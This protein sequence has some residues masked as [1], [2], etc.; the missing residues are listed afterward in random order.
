MIP[1]MNKLP[2]FNIGEKIQYNFRTRGNGYFA[3]NE[4]HEGFIVEKYSHNDN[5][6]YVKVKDPKHIISGDP[7]YNAIGIGLFRKDELFKCP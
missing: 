4:R 2:D 5:Y 1:Q 6:Y 7:Q 3:M